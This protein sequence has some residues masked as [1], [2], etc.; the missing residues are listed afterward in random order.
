MC[1]PRIFHGDEGGTREAYILDL[2]K[3]TFS[4]SPFSVMMWRRLL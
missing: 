2:D 4:G 3:E 1:L